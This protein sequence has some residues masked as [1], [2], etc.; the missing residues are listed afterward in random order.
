MCDGADE[1]IEDVVSI[2]GG[3]LDKRLLQG[4][5]FWLL[6]L[7]RPFNYAR[8]Q[9]CLY[10]CAPTHVAVDSVMDALRT[11]S[12]SLLLRGIYSASAM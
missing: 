7:N 3:G 1:S 4:Y 6:F 9:Q 5:S 11:L 2:G 12:L 10:V 8:V